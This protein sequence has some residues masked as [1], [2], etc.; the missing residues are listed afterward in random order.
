MPGGLN[1]TD[2]QVL[3][4]STGMGFLVDVSM[5][6]AIIPSDGGSD[7]TRLRPP[8]KGVARAHPCPI[9]TTKTHECGMLTNELTG[10]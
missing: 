5:L 6:P 7:S 8:D 4:A 2:F 1:W 10:L 3:L 9:W